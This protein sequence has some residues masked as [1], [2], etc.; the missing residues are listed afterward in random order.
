MLNVSQSV[1]GVG[2]T[3]R[4]VPEVGLAEVPLNRAAVRRREPRHPSGFGSRGPAGK[5]LRGP[6]HDGRVDRFDRL[7]LP[8]R[9]AP[10]SRGVAHAARD[11]TRRREGAAARIVDHAILHAVERVAF[12]RHGVTDGLDRLGRQRRRGERPLRLHV[13]EHRRRKIQDG[14][15]VDDAVEVVGEALRGNQALPAAGGAA[16]EVRSPRRGAVVGIG[17]R[18]GRHRR[19]VHGAERVVGEFL[20]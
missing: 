8:A 19:D 14:S 2:P 7:Q 5:H 10:G 17:E 18:L 6:A 4:D 9:E 16:V 13:A 20:R 3:E 15:A 11:V 1:L 12:R